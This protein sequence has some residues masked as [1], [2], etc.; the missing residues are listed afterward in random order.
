MPILISKPEP[1]AEDEYSQRHQHED[2]DMTGGVTSAV[3]DMS[4]VV[5]PGE[6]ITDDRKWMRYAALGRGYWLDAYSVTEAMAHTCC[7]N[8]PV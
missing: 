8:Q 7:Q 6:V 3:V 2:V 5:T 4:T 1:A